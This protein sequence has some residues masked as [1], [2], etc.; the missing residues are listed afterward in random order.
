MLGDLVELHLV[1][2]AHLV[3][4]VHDQAAHAGRGLDDDDL[5]VLVRRR[6]DRA[7]A[8]SRSQT[9][10]ILPRRLMTP[11]TAGRLDDTERG[12]VSG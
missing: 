12:S 6:G 5:G 11:R 1:E 2:R 9:G 7:E 3:D 10:M 4:L 8:R